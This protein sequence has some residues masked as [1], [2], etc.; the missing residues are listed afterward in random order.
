MKALENPEKLIEYMKEHR[1]TVEQACEKFSLYHETIE[2]YCKKF[3]HTPPRKKKYSDESLRLIYEKVMRDGCT[4]A[5]ACDNDR[6]LEKALS[7]YIRR[8]RK[9][10]DNLE[11]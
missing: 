6:Q 7:R 1:L 10:E 5:S 2:K 8:K 9:N 3:E 4:Q 11:L